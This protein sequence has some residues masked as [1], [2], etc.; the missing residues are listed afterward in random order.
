MR[1]LSL[2]DD[3]IVVEQPSALGQGIDI[4]PGAQIIGVMVIGQ[5]RWMFRTEN[6][7][8]SRVPPAS[9]GRAQPA[10]RLRMPD[11][12][13]RC[14]RRNFYRVSTAQLN[15]PGV[16]C[17]PLLDPAT[18]AIAEADNRVRI[19]DLF[20]AHIS[21][22]ALDDAPPILPQVGPAFQ[23]SLV[24]LGGGGAGLVIDPNDRPRLDGDRLYWLRID[25]RPDIPAPVG[26][27]ARLK[28]THYDSA[29]RVYAGMAFEFGFDPRHQPFVIDLITRYV[30]A[31]QRGVGE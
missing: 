30:A 4:R 31:V 28:H 20:N 3:E 10:L 26:V 11:E 13:E 8:A 1:I 18:A 22:L 14:Q 9:G 25:L 15:L 24:N 21:G 16:E 2:L 7:G 27:T 12:V 19:L 29:Q 6:L 17:Y 5:N 23:A